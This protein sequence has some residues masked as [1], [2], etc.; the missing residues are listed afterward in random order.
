M[1]LDHTV[2]PRRLRAAAVLIAAGLVV[3]ACSPG[4]GT[5]N[6]P[7]SGTAAPATTATAPSTAATTTG[8]TVPDAFTAVTV[9]PLSESTFPFL[10]SDGKYHVVYDLEL[11]NAAPIP[12]T[13]DRVDVVDAA[14]PA[15]VLAS[16]SGTAAR[17]AGLPVRRLQPAAAAAVEPG[18]RHRVRGPGVA[19]AARRLHRRLPAERSEGR[20]APPLRHGRGQPGVPG[21]VAFDYLAAPFDIGAG[22]PRVIG[23]PVKGERWV[24]LNGCCL[25]GFPHRTSLATFNGKLVNGQR[26]AIDWK[27]TNA[28]GEFYTGDRTKNESYVD[29]GAPIYAVAD[30]TVTSLLDEL[31][32]NPP[33]IL[34]ANDPVLG[35]KITVETVDGNHI[36]QDIGGG[37]YAFYAH[38]QKGSLL[39]EARRRR[40]RRAQVIAKLGNTGNANASHMHFQLMDGPSVLGSDGLP[41][42]IDRFA[43]AG[44]VAPQALI[45]ADDYLSGHVPAEPPADPGAAHRP[46]ALRAGDRRLPRLTAATARPGRP[47]SA[48]RAPTPWLRTRQP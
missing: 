5:P 10:G 36:V 39:V 42:V 13:V 4:S 38:L 47:T 35:P 43:Y 17:S 9:R 16:Y 19:R 1:S 34:P 44:Q 21:P 45:D 30:G 3:A 48:R 7:A 15:T 29:Y 23:P 14:N 22:T 8:V 18:D 25:P 26:F 32:P 20:R 11:T 28:N 24:A 2:G 27:Q 41:Y 46:A 33:G 12:A 6:A 40:S 31:D 37:A